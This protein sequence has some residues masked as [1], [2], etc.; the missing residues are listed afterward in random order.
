M[1]RTA[2]RRAVVIVATKSP[3][4]IAPIPPALDY[5]MAVAA[6]CPAKV[7]FKGI[8][9]IM[10]HTWKYSAVVAMTISLLFAGA[11]IR[12]LG[13]PFETGPTDLMQV[14][15]AQ[16]DTNDLWLDVHCRGGE[17]T[18]VGNYDLPV[19]I[20][21][22]NDVQPLRLGNLVKRTYGGPNIV[23]Y[24]D[25]HDEPKIRQWVRH[26]PAGMPFPTA[27]SG[28]RIT[29]PSPF[30][31]KMTGARDVWH[32]SMVVQTRGHRW[33][34]GWLAMDNIS[35]KAKGQIIH[36]FG[37]SDYDLFRGPQS[38]LRDQPRVLWLAVMP[39]PLS[40]QGAGK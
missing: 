21:L 35:V 3:T 22:P 6:A 15:V 30:V 36:D 27:D 37:A 38:P 7:D 9:T 17:V 13:L 2:R 40:P 31:V 1:T 11:K 8:G 10:K 28:Y 20:V 18:R 23:L 32:F 25:T 16:S 5:A 4:T 34:Y 19:P 14:T 39:L 24:F 33:S 29:Y 12:A 26:L